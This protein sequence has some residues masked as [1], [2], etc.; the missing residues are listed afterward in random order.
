MSALTRLLNRIPA[1]RRPYSSFGG[2]GYFNSSR[3]ARSPVAT[4]KS[5]SDS[6]DRTP[7]DSSSKASTAKSAQS[8]NAPNPYH[9]YLTPHPTVNSKDFKIHQFFSLYRPLLLISNP[10]SI[11]TPAS[12]DAPLFRFLENAPTTASAAAEDE[13]PLS[14]FTSLNLDGTFGGSTL[15]ADGD[16][17]AARQLHYAMTMNTVGATVD[18]EETL[19]TLGINLSNDQERVKLQEQWDRE[20]EEVMMD[21]VKR[22]RRKKMKKHKLKK[23]RRATRAQR[24]RIGR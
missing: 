12:P 17:E 18:W 4:A 6:S 3:P 20:W 8:Y 23:R 5:K 11:F 14:P 16:A 21:S 10:P 2:G 24:M 9:N 22:K 15:P 7:K 1:T 19:K 13:L